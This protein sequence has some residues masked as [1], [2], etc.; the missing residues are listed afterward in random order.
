MKT[1]RAIT[2]IIMMLLLAFIF[3]AIFW[4]ESGGLNVMIFATVSISFL[5]FLYRDSF[6]SKFTLAAMAGTLLTAMSILLYSSTVGKIAFTTSFIILLGFVFQ[7]GLKSIHYSVSQS[8][9]NLWI[10]MREPFRIFKRENRSNKKRFSRFMRIFI[11]PF[12]FF[13]LFYVLYFG[14][15]IVF[16]EITLTITS[17]IGDA[18]DAFFEQISFARIMFFSLALFL[19]IGII[20]NA[21]IKG[22]FRKEQ[23][24]KTNLTREEIKSDNGGQRK[25]K[26]NGLK[27]EAKILLL[28]LAM[29]NALMLLVNSLDIYWIWFNFEKTPD[30]DLKQFV[31][32]G[33]YLL[34][35]SIILA[36]VI[37]VFYFRGNL[38][39]YKNNK[40]LKNATYLWIFQNFIMVISVAMRNYHYYHYYGLAYKRIGVI[41]FLI[42]TIVGLISVAIKIHKR[43]SLYFLMKINSWSVYAMMILLP[44]INWDMI[45][46]KTNVNHPYPENIEANFLLSLSNKTLPYL[47]AHRDVFETKDFMYNEYSLYD[48]DYHIERFL[49]EKKESTWLSWNMAEA[50]ALKYFQSKKPLTTE[51]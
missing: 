28:L 17:Y 26:T 20:Y 6:R 29:I 42:L 12:V 40:L 27:Y 2:Q 10:S 38:N 19:S 32:E 4:N 8:I 35:F 48:L 43:K 39:Y 13:L 23:K 45:I 1:K 50:D 51:E 18:I 11:V 5:V 31:H 30:L 37:I 16:K 47:D 9:I 14:A 49:G 46:V 44:L 41:I 24:R 15:N 3:N 25:F 33:T 36:M 34:I 7:P 22:V 21:G